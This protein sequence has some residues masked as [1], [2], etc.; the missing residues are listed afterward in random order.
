M[1]RP[2]NPLIA[3]SIMGVEINEKQTNSTVVR[4]VVPSP[5]HCNAWLE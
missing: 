1:T 5:K 4:A 3:P 2:T